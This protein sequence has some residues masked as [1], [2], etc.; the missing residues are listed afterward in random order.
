MQGRR[1]EPAGQR[2]VERSDAKRQRPRVSP[3]AG[4]S[5][6]PQCAPPP[7]ANPTRPK[8][9]GDA[10]RAGW[11]TDAGSSLFLFCSSMPSRENPAPKPLKIL[12]RRAAS[13][14]LFPTGLRQ[15]SP[16]RPAPGRVH[17]QVIHLL[18]G[19]P[20]A[21]AGRNIS[22][23]RSPHAPTMTASACARPLSSSPAL[24]VGGLI[25][26]YATQPDL[27]AQLTNIRARQNEHH[28]R[29]AA[30]LRP[31]TTPLVMA[32]PLS[33]IHP[34][35]NADLTR[36]RKLLCVCPVRPLRRCAGLAQR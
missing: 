28:R 16:E 22:A 17:R 35:P 19:R 1:R 29:A 5:Q 25:Y 34:A 6:R 31:R 27:F 11:L 10:M 20:C 4:R 26:T 7:A 21:R 9:A 14:A 24:I 33:A 23:C 2:A 18:G 8:E 36:R 32:G 30:S 3:S 13:A 15:A 12:D